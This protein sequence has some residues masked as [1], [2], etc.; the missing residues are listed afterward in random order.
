[1]VTVMEQFLTK[2]AVDVLSE[3]QRQVK[4]EGFT[5]AHDDL[6]THGELA[7]AAA[8]YAIAADTAIYEMDRSRP[9]WNESYIANVSRVWPWRWT[10][11]KP[12]NKRRDLVKAA[13]LLLAE[14]ER[15][16]RAASTTAK[17]A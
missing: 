2:A 4:V 13:A 11:W 17:A 9:S 5:A 15:V 6:H 14:I 1:M 16:D 12:A 7:R 10:L 8:A 3:R